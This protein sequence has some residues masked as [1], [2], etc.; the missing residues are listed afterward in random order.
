MFWTLIILTVLGIVLYHFLIVE[1][2]LLQVGSVEEEE[3]EE[4]EERFIQRIEEKEAEALRMKQALVE[5]VAREM[6]EWEK[7]TV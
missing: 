3:E 6:A 5:L 1:R 4:G 2:R 7:E